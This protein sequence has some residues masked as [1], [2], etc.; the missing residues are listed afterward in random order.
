MPSI[1]EEK[2]DTKTLKDTN[3]GLKSLL[4]RKRENKQ[5]R[6]SSIQE[7]PKATKKEGSDRYK[8]KKNKRRKKGNGSVGK[9]KSETT[10]RKFDGLVKKILG[11]K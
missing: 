11:T 3:N 9:G 8:G 6:K 10:E 5:K 4:S 1:E 2:S 7:T